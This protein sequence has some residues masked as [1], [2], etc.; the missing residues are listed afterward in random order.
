M[1]VSLL[2]SLIIQMA[3]LSTPVCDVSQANGTVNC[4]DRLRIGAWNMHCNADIAGPF[5][6]DMAKYCHIIVTSEH[7]LYDNEL[8]KLDHIVPRYKSYALPSS[9]RA[10]IGGTA[11]LWNSE[12]FAFR[13]KPLPG[14]SSDR[15]TVIE[16]QADD[17]VYFI[18]SVY[19]PHQTCNISDFDVELNK[20]KKIL[21]ECMLRGH[22]IILGDT[23]VHFPAGYDIR[24]W[25]IQNRNTPKLHSLVQSYDMYIADIGYKAH[26]PNITYRGGNGSSYVD[27]IIVPKCL[28]PKITDCFVSGDCISNVSDHSP[29]CIELAVSINVS[30]SSDLNGRRVAWSKMTAGEIHDTYTEPLEQKVL[31]LWNEL[32]FNVATPDEIDQLMPSANQATLESFVEKFS[33]TIKSASD[34]LVKN[35]FKKHQKPWWN[36]ELSALANAKKQARRAWVSAGKQKHL[37]E[38]DAYKAAKKEFRRQLR[39]YKYEYEL[40]AMNDFLVSQDIDARYFWYLVNRNKCAKIAS[41]IVSNDGVVLTDPDAIRDDWTS[42][43]ECLYKE[44]SDEKYDDDFK[45]EIERELMEMRSRLPEGENLLTGGKINSS[46]VS[47]MIKKLKRNKAAG[48]DRITA[49]ELQYAGPLCV[50]SVTWMLNSIVDQ[51]S[52]PVALKK[53]LLVPIPKAEKDSSIKDNNRGITLLSLFYKLLEKMIIEREQQWFNDTSV[54]DS[55]QSS[56][57]EKCSCLHSS[58]IVQETVAHYQNM[59]CTVHGAGLDARKAFDTVWIDGL[60]YKLHKAGMNSAALK[61]ID[62]AYSNFSCAVF[63]SGSAGRWFTPLRGVH[64]G[65]PLSMILYVI[66]MNDLIIELRF[67]GKGVIIC[68]INVSSP[69]HADDVFLLALF[70]MNMNYLLR[71]VYKY[72]IRWRYMFNID[73]TK[74]LR[75]GNDNDPNVDICFGGDVILP[76]DLCKHMGIHLCTK[77]NGLYDMID[78]RAG[79]V[80]TV[81]GAARGIGDRSVPVPPL[82]LSKI[83]WAV[84]VPKL[85]YGLDVTHVNDTLMTKLEDIHRQNAKLVQSLPANTHN[86]APL[87]TLGWISMSAHIAVM[88]IMFLIRTLCLNNE[89]IY[90]R[91]VVSRLNAVQNITVND[92][93]HIG[94][95]LS[96]WDYV[97]KYQLDHIVLSFIENGDFDR[98]NATKRFVKNRIKDYEI[99]RWRYTCMLYRGLDLYSS[100]ITEMKPCAWWKFVQHHP[101]ILTQ[102]ASVVA[103]L[104]NNQP[105]G[106]QCN[107]ES[108]ICQLC[109]DRTVDSSEHILFHCDSLDTV[110]QCVYPEL[111]NVMPNAMRDCFETMTSDRKLS[112]ILTGMNSEFY[113][114]MKCIA[115]FVYALY[116]ER[117]RMYDIFSD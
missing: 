25:G 22:C 51:T 89:S 95:V 76:S 19:L 10:G 30:F 107:H 46:E 26:G 63:L 15:M 37:H 54:I 36:D 49:E 5:L 29:V 31:S 55:I 56:G 80:K 17:A 103:L 83:Y 69:C 38:Y 102:A 109:I 32:G 50:S 70:K 44:G 66:Y 35:K 116:K 79:K 64:Q 53:G 8:Y 98:I 24:T 90:R 48:W 65:A 16:L 45:L 87:A 97:R 101:N 28:I 4:I 47:A 57:K 106:L 62:N 92:V 58:F 41:P 68:N 1:F 99:S 88:K 113:D 112:F 74:Y 12:L 3:V 86:P 11:I 14:I 7:G 23:N 114:I 84:G 72:S 52:I 115:N 33:E 85:T 77:P 9:H 34:K 13:I 2:Y 60:M 105:R 40:N 110:R 42:Y 73:K 67:S 104:M 94:P 61:L 96:C 117:K 21:D 100:I 81:L 6:N 71:I 91:I 59:Q 111:L 27:H 75:W 43:Y 18:I 82:T 78:M 108:D 93:R 39:K 20:L